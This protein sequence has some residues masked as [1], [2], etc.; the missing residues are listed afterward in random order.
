MCFG[1]L[2]CYLELSSSVV[3]GFFEF[4]L[5]GLRFGFGGFRG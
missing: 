3:E 2:F 4:R 5:F 1:L